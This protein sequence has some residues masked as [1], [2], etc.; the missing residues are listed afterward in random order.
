MRNISKKGGFTLIE[1][2]ATLALTSIVLVGFLSI[3]VACYKS[4]H[5]NGTRT[6]NVSA[7]ENLIGNA[8]KGN[9]TTGV[10]QS[11]QTISIPLKN[12]VNATVTTATV[13]GKVYTFDRSGSNQTTLSTFVPN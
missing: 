12:S 10:V 8:V 7:A 4:I 13:S 11:T 5:V 9:S 3:I 2:I 6:K 1:E